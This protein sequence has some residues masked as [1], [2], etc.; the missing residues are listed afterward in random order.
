MEH[1]RGLRPSRKI[2]TKPP[3]TQPREDRA[4]AERL[5]FDSRG[6][7]YVAQPGK[8]STFFDGC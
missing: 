1:R 7:P 8:L 6:N 4:A 2:N 5:A 3:R